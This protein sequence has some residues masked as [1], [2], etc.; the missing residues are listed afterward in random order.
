MPNLG[1]T[2]YYLIQ[3]DSD[4]SQLKLQENDIITQLES[5]PFISSSGLSE[6]LARFL[7]LP[8][9]QLDATQGR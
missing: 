9:L 2:R 6:T 4:I 8:G 5:Q 1:G 3:K 7:T